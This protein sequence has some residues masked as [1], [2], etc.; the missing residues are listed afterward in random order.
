MYEAGYSLINMQ[1]NHLYVIPGGGYDHLDTRDLYDNWEPNKFYDYNLLEKIPVYSPQMLG[2]VYMLWNDMCGRLDVG[3]SEYDLYDRF[4]EP[5][6][7]LSAGLWG[8]R[9]ESGYE[10][11]MDQAEQIGQAS[12]KL[13]GGKNRIYD[14]ETGLE[15]YYEVDIR[16]KL[17][18]EAGQYRKPTGWKCGAGCRADRGRS[19]HG[20]RGRGR[21]G[22]WCVD[23]RNHGR[24]GGNCADQSADHRREYQCL[25]DVGLLCGGAGN[26]PR[27]LCAGGQD[28]YVGIRTSQGRMGGI[29]SGR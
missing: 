4:A 27:R 29:E 14:E 17:S 22:G 26:R 25:R 8:E 21:G 9:A 6:P 19:G 10:A 23:Q 11:F 28:L 3:I 16:V 20:Q 18:D 7:V 12:E 24:T 1:N 2:A 5:L 13:R 15:P